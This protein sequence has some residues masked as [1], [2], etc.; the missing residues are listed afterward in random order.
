MIDPVTAIGLATGAFN[1][2]KTMIATGKDIQDMAGQLGQWGKAISDLDY[3]HSK[4]EKP[5]WYKKLGGGVQANAVEVW[6]HKKKA[7]EMREELRSY[8]SAVYGPSAW[9]E[10]VHLEG[11]MRKQ[12]KEAVYAAQE[13]KE[14]FIA[15]TFGILITSIAICG[16]GALVYWLGLTQ[17]KW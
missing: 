16:M 14:K 11:V 5:A 1:S 13:M 7:D 2:I 12:Q 8:I 9:K 4:A 15:W 3:A 17:G 6:M 10:I